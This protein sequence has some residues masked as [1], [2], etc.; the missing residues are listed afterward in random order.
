MLRLSF[1]LRKETKP[2]DDLQ[3]YFEMQ[4][5]L[6]FLRFRSVLAEGGVGGGRLAAS[7]ETGGILV[8]DAGTITIHI[9]SGYTKIS[10]FFKV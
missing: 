8:Q 10:D 1:F 7:E 6:G 2:L 3:I 4:G 9:C 5:C